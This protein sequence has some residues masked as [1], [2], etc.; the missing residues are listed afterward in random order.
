MTEN[1]RKPLKLALHAMDSRAVKTMMQFL[2]GPCE[3]AAIVVNTA[4]D[5]DV[6]VFD[7]D[8]P[9]SKNLLEQC[10]QENAQKPVIVLSVEDFVHEGVL[11]LKK[12]VNTDAM[13]VVLNQARTLADELSKQSVQ[14]Q[15]SPASKGTEQAFMD[16]FNDEL[17]HFITASTWDEPPV[18]KTVAETLRVVVA[19]EILPQIPVEPVSAPETIAEEP[20]QQPDEPEAEAEEAAPETPVQAIA[21]PEQPVLKTYTINLEGNKTSKHQISMRMDENN[22]NKYN[23]LDE[24]D[25]YEY[26]GTIDKIDPDDPKQFKDASYNPKDYFQGYF[27]FALASC[28]T[29]NQPIMLQSDWCPIALL[30]FTQEVWLDARDS[31]LKAFAEIRLKHKSIATEIYA[32]P[33]DPKTMTMN[34]ALDKFQNMDAFSWKLASWTSKGRYPQDI[35]YRLPV[36]LSHWPNFTRLL[37]TPHA[38][39][40]AALLNQGPRTMGNIAELLNIK[41]QHVFVFISAAYAIGL[42]GQAR[43]MADNLVQPPELTPDKSQGSLGRFM[44]KLR[45]NKT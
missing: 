18:P 2:L 42:A 4:E 39:R 12:P 13:L 27:Q 6:D 28:R 24:I 44:N 30:P 29:K 31:E 3:G 43:R 14:Q 21:E 15:T 11:H 10:L 35:D 19:P 23:G 17:Y 33:I 36:Y 5:A 34:G 45:G 22:T 9:A 41:P 40:I 16:L 32:S 7:A 26:L 25:F 1:T 20:E 8:L 38:L 37:I